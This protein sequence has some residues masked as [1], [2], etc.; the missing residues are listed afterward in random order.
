MT[1]LEI[2]ELAKKAYNSNEF[3]K[4]FLGDAS[5]RFNNLKHIPANVPTD[6]NSIIEHG[7]YPLYKN[8]AL[9]IT[10]L[11]KKALKNMLTTSPIAIWTA[12]SIIWSQYWNELEKCS[13]YTIVDNELL[14]FC[15]EQIKKHSDVLKNCNDFIGQTNKI[16][17]LGDIC[18]LDENFKNR[19]GVSIL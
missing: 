2:Y 16:G 4:L 11:V 13:P 17:L 10:E 12:Y 8:G 1:K 15:R 6:L 3:E 7:L 18:R 14:E 9:D 5:Y 19:F